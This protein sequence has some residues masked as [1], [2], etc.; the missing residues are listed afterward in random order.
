MAP[1]AACRLPRAHTV[2]LF[3][4]CGVHDLLRNCPDLIRNGV[5]SAVKRI[6][7]E[8]HIFK[9]ERVR[10]TH[11]RSVRVEHGDPIFRRNVVRRCLIRDCRYICIE[12]LCRFRSFRPIRIEQCRFLYVLFLLRRFRTVFLQERFC[13]QHDTYKHQN[14]NGYHNNSFLHN[15]GPFTCRASLTYFGFS[16]WSIT[17]I[18]GLRKMLYFRPSRKKLTVVFRPQGRSIFDPGENEKQQKIM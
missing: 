17:Q 16:G 11:Q 8:Q 2:R 12:A 9:A 5:A 3:P 10:F 1:A 14:H 18:S 4:A 6:V 15:T 13:T 7:R